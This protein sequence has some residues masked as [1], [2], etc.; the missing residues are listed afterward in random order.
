MRVHRVRV[1]AVAAVLVG[2]S[3]LFPITYLHAQVPG[4][5]RA[6]ELR[7]RADQGD[8]VAQ[9]T[10][11]LMYADG[12]GVTQDYVEA[13]A[14]FIL[15]IAQ[16]YGEDYDTFVEARDTVARRMTDEQVEEAR[17]RAGEWEPTP[18]P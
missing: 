7:V 13:Y 1:V 14:W 15:A 12:D 16:A 8:A 18:E 11:G 9:Y 2:I 5:V 17:Q 3:T 10:L 6:Q 4:E